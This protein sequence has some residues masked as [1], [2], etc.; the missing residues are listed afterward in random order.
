MTTQIQKNG[1]FK[2]L[3]NSIGG[4]FIGILLIF[5]NLYFLGKNEARS[6]GQI[7]AIDEVEKTAIMISADN[8]NSQND[9]KLVILSGAIS[10]FTNQTDDFYNVVSNSYVLARKVAMYQ[11]QEQRT[12]SDTDA[13]VK[14]TYPTSWHYE[15]I[16]SDSYPADCV[17]PRWPSGDEFQR[18]IKFASSARLGAFNINEAQLKTI[19]SVSDISVPADAKIP[20]GFRKDGIYITNESNPPTVGNIRV[21]FATNIAKDMTLI[22]RQSGS[23]IEDYITKNKK[24]FN[25]IRAGILTK[26]E[27]VETYRGENATKTWMLRFLFTALVCSG[28]AMVFKPVE[29]L[30]KVIP[31]LGKY[32]AGFTRWVANFIGI[33]LGVTLSLIV[34]LLSW[35]LVRPLYAII[36]LVVVAGLIYLI[37][38][39]KRKA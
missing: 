9:G 4:I 27:L 39:M 30:L 6:I 37:V 33:L 16:N 28:F 18:Y 22:G 34:I 36:L 20:S 17:N 5:A 8:V 15:H 19:G 7:R 14:I 32:I 26:E 23:N 2:R 13:E 38:K 31:F 10:D 29:V 12:G 11:Y 1:F 3:L 35:V 25:E 21:S 24:T